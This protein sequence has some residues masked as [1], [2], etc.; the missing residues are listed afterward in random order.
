MIRHNTTARVE[1]HVLDAVLSAMRGFNLRTPARLSPSGRSFPAESH[2]LMLGTVALA[3]QYQGRFADI[4]AIVTE[5]KRSKPRPPA[6]EIDTRVLDCLYVYIE[7]EE[8]GIVTAIAFVGMHAYIRQ[9]QRRGLD[10]S[11]EK[12]ALAN[13]KQAMREANVSTFV[14]A[15]RKGHGHQGR[16]VAQML[17]DARRMDAAEDSA[18]RR[19]RARR[20]KIARAT[21]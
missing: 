7:P 2:I 1:T 13:M 21:R 15:T 4:V 17:E 9:L 5:C 12:L 10:W 11:A 19:R 6:G 8:R 20:Q 16:T 3:K 18:F 14:N